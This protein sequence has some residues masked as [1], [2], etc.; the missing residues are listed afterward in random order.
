[1]VQFASTYREPIG[2]RN[3]GSGSEWNRSAQGLLT[4][5]MV[6][7]DALIRKCTAFEF[8]LKQWSLK[9]LSAPCARQIYPYSNISENTQPISTNKVLN[10]SL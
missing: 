1:M 10:E 3:G 7:L 8:A 4:V 5:H 6:G 9:N 2:G